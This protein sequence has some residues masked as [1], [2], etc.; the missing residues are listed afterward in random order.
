VQHRRA[1]KVSQ[2]PGREVGLAAG[3]LVALVVRAVVVAA[4]FKG[5]AAHLR[6]GPATPATSSA[7]RLVT[8]R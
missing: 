2:A 6:R 1:S 4:A 5:P 3:V 7:I 8:T